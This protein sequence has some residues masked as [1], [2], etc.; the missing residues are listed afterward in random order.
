MPSLQ[1][2]SES[3]KGITSITFFN[4]QFELFHLIGAVLIILGLFLSNREIKNA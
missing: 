4:E 2:L 3:L 1:V